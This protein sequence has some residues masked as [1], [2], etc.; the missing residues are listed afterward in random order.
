[1]DLPVVVHPSAVVL[2]SCYLGCTAVPS[3][4]VD[5]VA[6]PHCRHRRGGRAGI[7]PRHHLP[8]G[9]LTEV[10]LTQGLGQSSVALNGA[11]RVGSAPIS[12]N[13]SKGPTVPPIRRFPE[14][15]SPRGA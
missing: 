1:M 13:R 9:P 8:A 11:H 12:L 6:V 4:L 7:P 10:A 3:G 14:G 5:P 15:H 2:A